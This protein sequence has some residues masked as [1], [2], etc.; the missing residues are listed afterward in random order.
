MEHLRFRTYIRILFSLLTL[1]V[2]FVFSKP[3]YAQTLN[4]ANYGPTIDGRMSPAQIV[5]PAVKFVNVLLYFSGAVFVLMILIGSIK[6]AT[7]LG[8]PKGA[9]GAN[10]TLTYAVI[11]FLAVLAVFTIL[12]IA[13][14]LFG[15]NP[16][17]TSLNIFAVIQARIC[18]FLYNGG[19]PIVTS[20][21]GCSF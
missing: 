1:L 17:F 10:L 21:Q 8:D 7:S 12:N 18:D 5:C 3:T 2:F 9:Q 16:A 4:C 11:G 14:R 15:I 20:V 13:T 19:Q 6:Y